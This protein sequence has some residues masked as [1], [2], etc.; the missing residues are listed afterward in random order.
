MKPKNYGIFR[1]LYTRSGEAPTNSFCIPNTI[2]S[3]DTTNKL[4]YWRR[5]VELFSSNENFPGFA[6]EKAPDVTLFG[7][8]LHILPANMNQT[9]VCMLGGFK[10]L[11]D[12]HDVYINLVNSND[13]IKNDGS[14]E[15][16]GYNHVT[17]T[18]GSNKLFKVFTINYIDSL[19]DSF[20]H[21]SQNA[22]PTYKS[23]YFKTSAFA[24]NFN[25][26]FYKKTAQ[27]GTLAI[28]TI[29]YILNYVYEQCLYDAVSTINFDD[30]KRN[31]I[32]LI[33]RGRNNVDVMPIVGNPERMV[34]LFRSFDEIENK[35]TSLTV[36]SAATMIF[37]LMNTHIL[38]AKTSDEG[39]R[40]IA[41]SNL[42][43]NSNTTVVSG[44]DRSLN[45]YT[46]DIFNPMY[47]SYTTAD[48]RVDCFKTVKYGLG[49]NNAFQQNYDRA[50]V[51]N[52]SG[53]QA[54]TTYFGFYKGPDTSGSFPQFR[55]MF[56]N[57]YGPANTVGTSWATPWTGN[58]KVLSVQGATLYYRGES[59]LPNA[60]EVTD[61]TYDDDDVYSIDLY[62][63][64]V[65]FDKVV[66][67][68]N[69]MFYLTLKFL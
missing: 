35:A 2:P 38:T 5:N 29:D 15:T 12:G 57:N 42:V 19:E 25:T 56:D 33:S 49:S 36:E 3:D 68:N 18:H 23:D 40:P 8:M 46:V 7:E 48:R 24:S 27:N 65:L 9:D 43:I 37:G 13:T 47:Q 54:S 58:T 62:S 60:I 39:S 10:F 26:D 34:E 69:L 44:D 17:V 63:F 11:Y 31:V 50:A 1:A 41:S 22:G 14:W 20:C 45:G 30:L 67:Y 64:E 51:E 61:L 6:I 55:A 59:G 52:I 66:D 53:T 4:D 16:G 32:G 28:T 21:F